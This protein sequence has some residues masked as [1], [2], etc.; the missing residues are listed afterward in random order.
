M[1]ALPFAQVVEAARANPRTFVQVERHPEQRCA[2]VRLDEP[3][4]LN[5]LSPPLL[6]QLVDRLTELT[7]DPTIRSVV[8]TGADPGFCVGG[9]FR[10]MRNAIDAMH[11]GVDEG[12]IGVWRFI[13]QLFGTVARL[14]VRSDQAFIAAV[15][16]PTAGVGW[17]FM[18]ACDHVICSDRAQIVPAFARLGLVPEVGTSW[19]LT[20]RLGYQGALDLYTSGETLDAQ[21]CL[22]LG[23]AQRAVPHTDLIPAALQRSAAFAELPDHVLQMAKP[24]LRQAADMTWEQTITLEEFAEPLTFTT[25]HFDHIIATLKPHSEHDTPGWPSHP[26]GEAVDEVRA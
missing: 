9:D 21:R 26:P 6:L 7:S 11:A 14:I 12:A 15:N 4:L 1:T 18:L 22:A 3:E 8:L 24:L 16:G 13:R 2:I 17:A 10:I 20:R 23:L 19:L 5:P 25:S